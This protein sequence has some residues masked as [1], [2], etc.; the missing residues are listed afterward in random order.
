MKE[1]YIKCDNNDEI[2]IDENVRRNGMR[3]VLIDEKGNP[4]ARYELSPKLLLGIGQLRCKATNV[5]IHFL[6]A[7]G[8]IM[9][10]MRSELT[11]GS[12]N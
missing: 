10:T 5:R 11:N 2:T 7:D 9:P 1:I 4:I 6:G 3:I 12:C 8:E